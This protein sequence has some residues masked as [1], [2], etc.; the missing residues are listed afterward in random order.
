MRALLASL[1]AII[2]KMFSIRLGAWFASGLL[3]LGLSYTT[4]HFAVAPF[5]ALVQQS[6]GQGGILL[7][8]AGFLGVDQAVTI[9]LSAIG[10][11]YGIA[12]ARAFLT[13]NAA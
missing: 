3:W 12:G 1:A 4:Y 5:R 8:W 13:K 2:G 6:M 11:K 7:G 10:V 9:V